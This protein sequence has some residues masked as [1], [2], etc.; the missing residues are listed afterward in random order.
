MPTFRYHLS[1]HWYKGNTHIH[2]T[3]SDGG[4]TFAELA[5]TYAGSGCHFAFRTDHWVTSA[6]RADPQEY[7]LLWLDGMELDGTDDAGV[8]YHVV[9][10]GSLNGISQGLGME[11]ALRSAREQGALL[12]L[13]HPLWTGNTFEDALRWHF[14][15]VEVYN[16]VCKF[17]NGKGDGLAYW[18]AML[19]R[20]PNTLAFA[21]DDAHVNPGDP[22]PSQAWVVV[23][24]P[25]CTPEAILAALRAGSFYSS[26]GPEIY[27]LQLDGDLLTV[28]CSPVKYARLVGPAYH[29]QRAASLPDQSLMRIEFQISESWPYM[30]LELEDDQGRRAWT[31]PLFIAE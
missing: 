1:G 28:A 14:D 20:Y 3:A 15:G 24:A 7:P 26:L 9:A 30:Y 2:S 25:A 16:H 27:D 21:A 8:Y 19:S 22:E 12:V 11:A 31:N 23:S 4:K 10:L 13:A 5:R 18:N 6:A 17:L 29:G